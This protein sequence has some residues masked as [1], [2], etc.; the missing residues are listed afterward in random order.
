[1][2][3]HLFKTTLENLKETLP[4]QGHSH[5]LWP[6]VAFEGI[7]EYWQDST[8]LVDDKWDKIFSEVIPYFQKTV[9]QLLNMNN[10]ERVAIAPN[11][12]ELVFR[13]ISSFDL[14]KD[15]KILT[16]N[17]EFYSLDRQLR[18]LDQLDNVKIERLNLEE[19]NGDPEV[20]I[21][22]LLKTANTFKPH[23]L[24]ISQCFFNTG[25]FIPEALLEKLVKGLEPQVTVLVDGYH[26]FATRKLHFQNL[27]ERIYFIAGGYKYAMAGEG[28][29]FMTVPTN[30]KLE[31]LY[32]GWMSEIE[33]LDNMSTGEVYYPENGRRFAGSTFDPTGLY[34]F[35]HIWSHLDDKGITLNKIHEYILE[36]Q[37]YFLE[38]LSNTQTVLSKAKL[39]LHS[40][41]HHAHFFSFEFPNNEQA[42]E[43]YKSVRNKNIIVDKRKNIVRFGFGLYLTTKAIDQLFLRLEE[44]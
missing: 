30:S 44:I 43:F 12:H 40:L 21:D 19:T 6:D 7:K 36:L 37:N 18:R 27:Q 14:C 13:L 10:P 39:H 22:Q 3:E 25:H 26:S 15:L 42:A 35:N 41:D 29:C 28:I 1:M 5:H 9:C 32:T 8:G 2:Y 20:I 4:F 24:A 17:S 23:L 11:T 16:T 34:R 33:R 38:K 31:P